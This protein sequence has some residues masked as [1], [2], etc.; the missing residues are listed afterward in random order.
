MINQLNSYLKKHPLLKKR[1]HTLIFRK[2][3]YDA[4]LRWFVWLWWTFP[5]YFKR[6]IAWTSRLDLVPFHKFKFGRYSRIEK[7]VVINNGMGDVELGD[8][9]HTGVG[10]VIIGP[11]KMEKHVGLS[12]YVRI[13]GMHHGIDPRTPHHHQPCAPAPVI[14]EEDAFIGTGTVIMGKKD[15]SPLTIGKYARVGANSV[16]TQ[17]IPPYSIAVG[18]PAKVI[19]TWDHDKDVWVKVAHITDHKEIFGRTMLNN[20]N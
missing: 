7:N 3:P 14:L 6:G 8:E 15:G 12:Q 4:R 11:V 18:N 13:L 10:C 19:K 5:R 17:D 9:V 2:K 1:V 16:V 20:F